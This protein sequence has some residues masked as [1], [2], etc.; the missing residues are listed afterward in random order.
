MKSFSDDIDRVRAV[1]WNGMGSHPIEYV[2]LA[3]KQSLSV[4]EGSEETI[5][6]AR[7]Q[8]LRVARQRE[9]WKLDLDPE[10]D[11]PFM[12]MR[13]WIQAFW[14]KSYR[15]CLD[16]WETEEA[17]EEVPMTALA[18]ITGANLKVLREV[19]SGVRKKPSVLKAA[20]EMTKDQLIELVTTK[21]GQHIEPVRVMPK[22][23]VAKFEHA[24]E[25]VMAVEE[26]NR[27]EALT[28]IAELIEQ[29]YL[30]PYEHRQEAG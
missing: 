16:A 13:R 1:D 10:L 23:D 8:V 26:C 22:V 28:K 25:M 19:S 7:M 18:E 24:V 30:V 11:Q 2:A 6:H 27:A 17:L 5:Y 15:Y 3:C 21:H 9:V 4:L 20:R 12:T 14:P 29:E